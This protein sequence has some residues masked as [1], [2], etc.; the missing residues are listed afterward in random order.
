MKMLKCS[1]ALSLIAATTSATIA[2]EL[3]VNPGLWK[4][5]STI[6]NSFSNQPVTETKQECIK[7]K[8]S[9]DPQEL[10]KEAQGCKMLDNKLDGKTVSFKMECDMNGGKS[11]INGQFTAEEEKGNG[12][13]D[14]KFEVQGMSMQMKLD[15]ESERLGDC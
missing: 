2:E 10:L 13:M 7:E 5:T 3:S 12:H 1:I 8:K 9:F 14:M 15:W 4:S 6:T 11:S